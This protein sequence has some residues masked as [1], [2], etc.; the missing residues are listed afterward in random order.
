MSAAEMSHSL[1]TNSLCGILYRSVNT[2]S[3][4]HHDIFSGISATDN[5]FG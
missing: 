3:E 1:Q 2:L 5:A 4:L